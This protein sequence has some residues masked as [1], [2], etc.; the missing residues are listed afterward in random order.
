MDLLRLPVPFL[1]SLSF[2]LSATDLV[3]LITAAYNTTKPLELQN[4]YL[5][6]LIFDK[7]Q[8]HL[9]NNYRLDYEQFKKTLKFYK[10]K[11]IE[12]ININFCQNLCRHT[13]LKRIINETLCKHTNLTELDLFN[14]APSNIQLELSDL[15]KLFR[16]CKNLKHLSFNLIPNLDTSE[17]KMVHMDRLESL[18]VEFKSSSIQTLF[19]LVFNHCL[20][21]THLELYSS[22]DKSDFSLNL[23]SH[24][25]P[26]HKLPKLCHLAT[27]TNNITLSLNEHL[28]DLINKLSSFSLNVSIDKSNHLLST[29][30]NE[31][32][33]DSCDLNF[34]IDLGYLRSN[35][36]VLNTNPYVLDDLVQEYFSLD[37][38]D[39]LNSIK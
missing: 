34:G 26:H 39:K 32:K 6:K 38:V 12:K 35:N 19:N 28:F 17:Q 5:F 10:T 22:Y 11:D 13:S 24:N 25:F 18:R 20:D 14:T 31:K 3:N 21:L 23:S 30:I 15:S 29:L 1:S 4:S 9:E 7:K 37:F 27:G 36:I 8:C 33:I 16:S 2:K